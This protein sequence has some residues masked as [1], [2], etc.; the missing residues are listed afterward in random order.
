MPLPT[1]H[2]LIAKYILFFIFSACELRASLSPHYHSHTALGVAVVAL[3]L[4]SESESGECEFSG[5]L[6]SLTAA[7]TTSCGCK[8]L[9]RFSH[10]PPALASTCRLTSLTHV[11]SVSC[12]L[13]L[14]LLTLIMSCAHA[15]TPVACPVNWFVTRSSICCGLLDSI[16]MAWTS[17]IMISMISG[18]IILNYWKP[19]AF[20]VVPCRSVIFAWVIM[21]SWYNDTDAWLPYMRCM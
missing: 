8:S 14:R 11:S 20:T 6:F 19:L 16:F 13:W 15:K 3:I 18:W 4:L 7:A 5:F 1:H 21:Y 12:D 17:R 9:H 10:L 2:Q